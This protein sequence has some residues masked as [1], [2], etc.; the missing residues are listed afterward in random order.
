M[1]VRR[2]LYLCALL[3][4]PALLRALY[5]TWNT[6]A[7]TCIDNA[8]LIRFVKH[9]G[10]LSSLT[11][12]VLIIPLGLCLTYRNRP[13]WFTRW[14]ILGWTAGIMVFSWI[15]VNAMV[16]VP[17]MLGM[18]S[19]DGPEIVGTLFLGGFYLPMAMLPVLTV[20]SVVHVLRG[21]N[22]RRVTLWTFAVVAFLYCCLLRLLQNP[23]GLQVAR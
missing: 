6:G 21:K 22:F 3:L 2:F 9:F 1:N 18:Y 20:C 11:L 17:S 13:Q 15:Y 23:P 4:L 12:F 19:I 8:H 14:Q 7:G 16:F 10:L 5:M